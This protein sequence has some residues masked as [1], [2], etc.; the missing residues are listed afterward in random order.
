MKTMMAVAAFA[1]AI[2]TAAKAAAKDWYGDC[3]P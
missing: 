3:L 1:L 2:G